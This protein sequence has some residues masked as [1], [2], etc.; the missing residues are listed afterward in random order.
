MVLT[1]F[2][3]LAINN[4][5]YTVDK[6]ILFCSEEI[7]KGDLP[8]WKRGVYQFILDFLDGSDFIIQ[9]TS[10]TTG[11]K[12]SVR[13]PKKAMV[14]SAKLTIKVLKLKPYDTALLC[15]PIEYIAGKMVVVRSLCAGLNLLLTEPSGT[16]GTGSIEPVDF[17]AL[18]PLQVYN[19]L[20]TNLLSRIR[21][22]IIGGAEI[23]GALEREI[24]KFPNRVF[25]T[26]GMAET[27]SHVALRRVNGK[28]RESNFKA[29]PGVR[30]S[31]DT[32]GCLVIQAPFLEGKVITNDLVELVTA[33]TFKWLG[34]Y[35]N[36]I[37]TGGIKVHPEIL[38]EK[39][40]G[41]L[42]VP[43]AIIGKPD[44]VLG[45]KIVLFVETEHKIEK[46]AITEL[47]KCRLDK[48]LVPKE[49]YTLGK[50]P[51][52]ASYKIDR[53]ALGDMIW[54]RQER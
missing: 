6:L 41:I 28:N 30:L 3:S 11:K 42:N 34:R 5:L 49:V 13:I 53:G 15:L 19:L 25:E 17:C 22:L 54:A 43:C 14:G 20:N 44:L 16:P 50:F 38:E 52:N 2:Q 26:Y 7:K 48:K 45:Q 33:N 47:L 21:T 10:G 1:D 32:R 31:L 23:G 8:E 51:R 4:R 39:I 36:I 29:L 37:N 40:Q 12:K 46:D 9:E 35:D 18:V 27:C 24:Q